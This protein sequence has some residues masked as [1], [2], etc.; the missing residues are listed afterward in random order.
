MVRNIFLRL[1]LLGEE[2]GREKVYRD[3]SR[4]IS[5]LDLIPAMQ[6]PG[7]VKTVLQ[8]LADARLVVTGVMDDTG[9]IE[10]EIAHEALIQHWP[11]LRAWLDEDRAYT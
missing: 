5:M 8:H 9:E 3:T 6:D 2:A 10:V 4:R 7:I 11:R 1:T